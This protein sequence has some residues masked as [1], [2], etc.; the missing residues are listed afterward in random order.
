MFIYYFI[1]FLILIGAF[2]N[3]LF[4]NRYNKYLFA[5]FCLSIG[6]F[7]GLRYE[8]GFDHE[9]YLDYFNNLQKVDYTNGIP[10]LVDNMEIGFYFFNFLLKSF[11]LHSQFILLI[12]SFFCIFSFYKFTNSFKNNYLLVLLAYVSFNLVHNHFSLVRQSICVGLIY[13]AIT[14]YLKNKKPFWI[15]FFCATSLI[16]HITSVFYILIL[17][18]SIFLNPNKSIKYIS[19]FLFIFSLSKIDL[20]F[21]FSK[22]L[23][24]TA[25][26]SVITSKYLDYGVIEYKTSLSFYSYII[27]N[28]I[29]IHFAFKIK[30]LN[31]VSDKLTSLVIYS[32][33]IQILFMTLFPSNYIL[34]SRISILTIVL[35][36]LLFSVFISKNTLPKRFLLGIAYICIL[37]VFFIYNMTSMKY[38]LAPYKSI[39][40]QIF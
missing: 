37:L 14:L 23:F 12:P 27:F 3:L 24:N 13:L 32:S 36:S 4:V 7:S 22:L 28:I 30:K 15:I 34:W 31:K 2:Y 1:Y 35:Q 26:L 33:F 9:P 10:Y 29:F 5:F 16:F 39:F 17:L 21:E 40:N 25:I 19:I 6:L 18:L 20:A 11:Y 8:T 38:G